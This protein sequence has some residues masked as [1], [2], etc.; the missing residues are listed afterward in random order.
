MPFRL[1]D[2]VQVRRESWGLLFYRQADHKLSFVRSG[3]WLRPAYFNGSW[4]LESITGDIARRTGVP[5]EII[6]RSLPPL[7]SR[8][9]DSRVISNEVR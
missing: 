7:A 2:G 6:E 1:A 9:A 5:V 4:G 3:D 8:L